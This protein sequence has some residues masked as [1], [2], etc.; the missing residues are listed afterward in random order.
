[1]T[2]KLN[3]RGMDPYQQTYAKINANRR[4]TTEDYTH[5]LGRIVF[6]SCIKSGVSEE[7]TEY[8][9]LPDLEREIIRLKHIEFL[10]GSKPKAP[11][12]TLPATLRIAFVGSAST[13]KSTLARWAKNNYQLPMINEVARQVLGELETNFTTLHSDLNATTA[14]QQE[15]FKRQVQVSLAHA[16]GYVSDRA[17]DNLAYAADAAD[18]YSSIVSDPS[19][20]KYLDHLEDVIIFFVRPHKSL[21]KDDGV[22]APIKWRDVL[23]IDGIIKYILRS[24][25]VPK[26][27]KPLR[28]FEIDSP[29][30]LDRVE[31]VRNVVALRG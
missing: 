27:G 26:T 2:P 15:V 12:I 7:K 4:V 5:L 23:R 14:Y 24:L 3:L 21:L 20:G 11:S 9:T 19:L 25:V 29:I 6:G 8:Y 18:N 22:R 30:L 16:G 13:G 17:H 1:M 10:H 28:Y 31:L